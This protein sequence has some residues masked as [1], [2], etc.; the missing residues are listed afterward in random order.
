MLKRKRISK[1]IKEGNAEIFLI[2]ESKL[3]MVDQNLV[4]SLWS[5]EKVGWSYSSLMTNSGG[6]ITLWKEEGVEVIFSFK[7]EVYLGVKLR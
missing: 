4:N 3:N 7:G 2:Q 5:R 1:I 6:L